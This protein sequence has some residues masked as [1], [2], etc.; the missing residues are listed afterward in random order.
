MCRRDDYPTAEDYRD[1]LRRER[2]HRAEGH[3]LIN[4]RWRLD[5]RRYE[6]STIVGG[7]NKVLS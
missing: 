3:E 2:E 6:L 7:E 5:G 4:W 1:A